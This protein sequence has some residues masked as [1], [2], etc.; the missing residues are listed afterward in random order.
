MAQIDT[1]NDVLIAIGI[2][3]DKSPSDTGMTWLGSRLGHDRGLGGPV[4]EYNLAIHNVT[5]QGFHT[6]RVY[7]DTGSSWNAPNTTGWAANISDP[8]TRWKR[9]SPGPMSD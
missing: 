6:D 7:P 2:D 9:G 8:R 3:T 4:S 1:P 5:G